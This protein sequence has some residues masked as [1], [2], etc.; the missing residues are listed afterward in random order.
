MGAS[1]DQISLRNAELSASLVRFRLQRP[2]LLF[3]ELPVEQK[4]AALV[5]CGEATGEIYDGLGLSKELRSVDTQRLGDTI[6]QFDGSRLKSFA[7]CHVGA[8]TEASSGTCYV[9]FGCARPSSS[10]EADF[11]QLLEN[12]AAYAAARG[13]SRLSAGMSL[14]RDEAYR[15]MLGRGFRTDIL[16]VAMHRPD[17]AGFC[18]PG[19]FVLD[20]WR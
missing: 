13:A 12:C 6:L 18:R 17:A 1:S 11:T 5:A 10:S 7:I 19:V 16:G 15:T 9:K 20:D 14:A 3:S 4:A 2:Y 8:N